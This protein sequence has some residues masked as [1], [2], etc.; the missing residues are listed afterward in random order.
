MQMAPA[1]LGAHILHHRLPAARTALP[2]DQPG[3]FQF[4]KLQMCF[5]W[6]RIKEHHFLFIKI[7]K[8]F[9]MLHEKAVAYNLLR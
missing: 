1:V 3:G 4:G 2:A 6:L 7:I 8:F 9:R 5:I